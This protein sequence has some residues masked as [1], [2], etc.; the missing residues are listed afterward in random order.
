MRLDRRGVDQHLRRRSAGR[1]QGLENVRP[2]PF[3]RPAHEAIVEGLVWA[4]DGRCVG[5][6][7]A[8][9]QDMNDAT[10]NAAVIDP[11]LAPRTGRKKRLKPR[12]LGVVQPK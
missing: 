8:G 12:K 6:A 7:G 9:L 2:H 5:P 3:G 10:D 4:I 1:G 11:R